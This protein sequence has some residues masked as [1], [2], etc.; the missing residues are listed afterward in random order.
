MVPSS[1][2]PV[3]GVRALISAGQVRRWVQGV[4]EDLGGEEGGNMI[5]NVERVG[6]EEGGKEK[7]NGGKGGAVIKGEGS[8]RKEGRNERGEVG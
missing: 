3:Q 4:G 1:G 7:R 8:G 5:G 6:G 2:I